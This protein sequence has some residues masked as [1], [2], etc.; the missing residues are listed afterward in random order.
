MGRLAALEW[1]PVAG[2]ADRTCAFFGP[3]VPA[4]LYMNIARFPLLT[5]KSS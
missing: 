1:F 3:T 4:K 5:S 2:A